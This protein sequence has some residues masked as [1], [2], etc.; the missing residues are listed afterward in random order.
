MLQNVTLPIAN[1]IIH[2]LELADTA[3]IGDGKNGVENSL[4]A[5][6]VPFIREQVHLEEALVGTLLHLDQIR[7]RDGR[8]DFRKINSLGRRAIVVLHFYSSEPNSQ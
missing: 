4:Q 8:L 5:R 2:E 1:G 6:V 7:D 3:K